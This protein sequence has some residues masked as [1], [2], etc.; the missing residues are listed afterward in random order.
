MQKK[1]HVRA[2]GRAACGQFPAVAAQRPA[3]RGASPLGRPLP[4]PRGKSICPTREDDMADKCDGNGGRRLEE[5][6]T[7]ALSL[8][9]EPG[10]WLPPGREEQGWTA[11]CA[12]G[13]GRV[14]QGLKKTSKYNLDAEKISFIC[15]SYRIQTCNLLIRSQMLYSVEL[16]SHLLASGCLS[17]ESG[18]KDTTFF[19]RT[20]FFFVFFRLQ[21]FNGVNSC[22]LKIDFFLFSACWRAC[23]CRLR[24]TKYREFR[25]IRRRQFRILS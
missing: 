6:R 5:E 4:H 1:S 18:C 16:R 3:G 25:Q 17:L 7:P 21:P 13:L 23:I 20:K 8:R 24:G 11:E 19:R 2:S 12:A 14:R 10:H 15:D 9:G 22:A